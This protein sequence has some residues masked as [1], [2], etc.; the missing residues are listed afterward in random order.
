MQAEK[1]LKR[2]PL[3]EKSYC[4]QIQDMLSR[5]VARKLIE[6]EI[7][8]YNGPIHYIAHHAIFKPTSKT[9]PVRIVF[10][11]SANFKGHVINEYW[12]KG[13]NVF[14]NT[15]FGILIRFRENIVGFMGDITKMYN[16]IRTRLLDQHC[17]RF[18]WREMDLNK[19]PD[20]YVITRVNM[21]D[22][23]SGSIAT[24]ALRKIAEMKAKEFPLES[25]ILINSSYMDDIIDSTDTVE[26]AQKIT[27]N[28]T[29]ILKGADFHIK[30]WVISS[31][32]RDLPI[33]F[34]LFHFLDGMERVLGISWYGDHFKYAVKLNFSKKKGKLR[35]EPDLTVDEI[36]TKIPLILTKRMILSQ[37]NGIFDPLG[38][39]S[40]YSKRENIIATFM[41]S[42]RK[43]WLG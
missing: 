9:T 38:L 42:W 37:L 4:G 16:S 43:D 13:P 7:A 22:K 33:E 1:R 31:E 2:D 10:N 6:N 12:A 30:N 24:S 40:V 39:I 26:S 23:A 14:L 19:K 20:T 28:I 5:N 17:H 3:Y 27:K 41:G 34:E 21:G 18:L 15:L 11:S 29:H 35:I 32:K 25:G 36:D 8:H